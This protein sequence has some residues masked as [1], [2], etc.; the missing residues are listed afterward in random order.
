MP[1]TDP[2]PVPIPDLKGCMHA[3]AVIQL[4]VHSSVTRHSN[5]KDTMKTENSKQDNLQIVNTA[6]LIY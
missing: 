5:G 3:L 1:H 6:E 4:C 2:T